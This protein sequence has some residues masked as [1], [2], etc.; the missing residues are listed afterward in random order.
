M[1][2]PLSSPY[3]GLIAPTKKTRNPHITDWFIKNRGWNR[4][5]PLVIILQQQGSKPETHR[6]DR[7]PC[8]SQSWRMQTTM[9]MGLPL[10][11]HGIPGL[12]RAPSSYISVSHVQIKKIRRAVPSFTFLSY[13][14]FVQTLFLV[15]GQSYR[16]FNASLSSV[17]LRVYHH[18]HSFIC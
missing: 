17:F 18:P 1:I 16:T 6:T 8:L 14:R 9:K 5:G 10:L 13:F 15:W 7:S 2:T 12:Q 4:S 3:K 11:T